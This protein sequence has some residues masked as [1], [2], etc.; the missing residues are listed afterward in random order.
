MALAR[1]LRKEC[2]TMNVL[3][4]STIAAAMVAAPAIA[5]VEI[6]LLDQDPPKT[7]V[8]KFTVDDDGAPLVVIWDAEGA[9]LITANFD[10][11]DHDA[12]G[13]VTSDELAA[14]PAIRVMAGDGTGILTQDQAIGR[15]GVF[16]M[17]DVDG[18]GVISRAEFEAGHFDAID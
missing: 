14:G 9:G 1:L 6:M 12:N 13:M 8:Q 18:D 4:A 3:L 10:S 7:E 5:E 11:W 16:V 2:K 17:R 15:G